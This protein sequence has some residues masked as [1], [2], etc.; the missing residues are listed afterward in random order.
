MLWPLTPWQFAQVV[1]ASFRRS[2]RARG[3]GRWLAQ[4]RWTGHRPQRA[5]RRCASFFIGVVTLVVLPNMRMTRVIAGIVVP[6]AMPRSCTGHRVPCWNGAFA[7]WSVG[8][9]NRS[10]RGRRRDAAK[11]PVRLIGES[12]SVEQRGEGLI[13]VAV[14]K[15]QGPQ[16]RDGQCPAIETVSGPIGVAKGSIGGED[17]IVP[18]PKLPISRSPSNEPKPG[19][20][21]CDS[22]GALSAPADAKRLMKLPLKSN[23]S[24]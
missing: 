15:C 20:C 7:D 6:L 10:G 14:A 1:A 2:A 19:R 12:G 11:N 9:R 16:A 18:S 24:T 13:G 17:L 21:K 3:K 5:I 22:P 8:V 4:R 23:T